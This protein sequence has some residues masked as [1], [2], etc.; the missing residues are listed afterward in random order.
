V[1]GELN[2]KM[3]GLPIRPEIN[4]EVALQPR[5][6]MG[7]IAPAYQPSPSPEERHRRSIYAYQ[8]RGLPNPM[9]EVFNKPNADISCEGRIASTVTPQAFTL[10]N[11]QNTYDRALAMAL[12]LK[13]EEKSLE[14]QMSRAMWL[15]WNRK[16]TEKEIEKSVAHAEKMLDYH[17]ENEPVAQEYPVMVKRTMFEEM[18]G[19]EFSYTEKLDIYENYDADTKAW[20][21]DAPTRAL[22][23]LCLVLYNSNEF[24]YIY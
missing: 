8:L 6:I 12:R 4:R 7:S 13:E 23:D 5:H 14:A 9:L 20:E 16:P 18:T 22:A 21:V 24:I 17:L 11:S 10:F 3:G 1:S 19:E 15:A 2:L